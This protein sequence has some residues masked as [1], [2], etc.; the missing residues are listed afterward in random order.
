MPDR[1]LPLAP[2]HRALFEASPGAQLVLAADPPR[3]TIVAVTD[4]YLRAT[5]TERDAILGRGLFE[6]FPDNPDAPGADSVRNLRA[7]IE[8]VIATGTAE[9]MA[10]Q[11]YDIRTGGR[12][13]ERHWRPVNAPVLGPDGRVT[14]IIHDVEDIT[15]VARLRAADAALHSRVHRLEAE[16]SAT[17]SR[18]H[19]TRF[20]LKA[21]EAHTRAI[22]ESS[23]EYAIL[24]MDRSGRIMSWNSGAEFV[25]GWREEDVL[26]QP[27]EFFFTPE[28]RAAGLPMQEL[29]TALI[30]GRAADERWH[31]RADGSRFFAHG[32]TM[33]LRDE[34]GTPAG[35]GFVK[36]MRDR[37][38]EHERDVA[39][40]A[41]EGRL[42]AVLESVS[43][44]FIAVDGEWRFI[45]FNA[46]AER[47]LE[48]RR[49]A[50]IGRLVWDVFPQLQ[51]TGVERRCREVMAGGPAVAFEA[52]PGGP[53]GRTFEMRAAPLTGGGIAVAFT[54][55]TERRA[56]EAALRASEERLRQLADALPLLISFIDRDE[57][58]GFV[59]RTYE[60]WFGTPPEAIVG[61]TIREVLGEEAYA[62]R[63]RQIAAALRGETMRFEAFTPRRDGS[64][65]DTDIHYLPRRGPDGAVDGFYVLVADVTEHRRSE[66]ALRDSEAKFQAIANSID[67]MVWSTRPD[68]FHDYFNQRWYE[69]TGVPTGATDGEGWAGM[70]H[71]DD[72]RRAREVWTH[73]LRT[74]EPYRIEYRLRHRSGQYR[75]VLGRAQ[76]VRDEDG[77]IIRWFGTCTDIQDIVEAR[78]VLARSREDLERLVEERTAERDRIWHN[79]NE[80][81]AVF[82]FD[83]LRRAINPAWSRVLGYD[84]ETLL[85]TPFTEVT[86]PDDLPRLKDA[87]Q[88]LA[89]GERIVAFEDRLRHADGSYRH[90]SWTGVPGDDVFY[91]IGRDVT[92][93]RIAEEQLRQAQKMEAVGQL[94]GGVAHDFNNLL[95]IIKSSTDLLR[96]PDLPEER[97]RR[98]VDAIADTVDR[99]S[100]LTGQLLAFARRQALKPEVFDVSER[101]RSVADMLSTVV[102]AR[103]RIETE[104]V[105]ETCFVEADLSQFETALINM[106]VNAR[107]AMAGEGTLRVAVRLVEGAAGLR[108]GAETVAVSLTDTGSGIA[109]ERLA[110]IFEPFFTTKEVGKGTGLGLSQ[111]Y[112]FAKQSGGDVD[113]ESEVGRGSTFTLYLPRVEGPG[114][115]GVAAV[116]EIRAR[117]AEH[118][119]GRRVLVVEDNAEVGTFS[120]Q[121]LQDLGY[122]TVWATN[123]E[124]ALACLA[125]SEPFDVVFSDVVMPGMSGVELGR[126]IRRRHPGLPVV[127]TSGYSEV[128]AEEGRHGFELLQKPYA[129][130][131]L[132]RVLRRVTRG[133]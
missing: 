58:Y 72:R 30:Q 62:A 83:G 66:R 63:R 64:R 44:G 38:A 36:V 73:S 39:L 28:D 124:E 133:G 69:Y 131:E 46:A 93:Q 111:V 84:E 102:G 15:E 118:G 59:N 7:S 33:P 43:D 3:F 71:A 45:L 89:G 117:P 20:A 42:Q 75:W 1:P 119:R 116:E 35:E 60:E 19:E 97:R 16:A 108:G 32:V 86:H 107:D 10:D 115:E 114:L 11:R 74:G 91:A 4:A 87:V 25:M 98:Y 57:R 68:G 82:G 85:N 12:F 14:H 9:R 27:C 6:V 121:I 76:P 13:E 47:L 54:D 104:I 40:R 23:T 100:K 112:G 127:L 34:A 51:G 8:R 67:Q 122:E 2:D 129:A 61:R 55:V 53:Q 128:L 24:S 78:E 110:H 113:V 18:L 37:T 105:C 130:E 48:H 92:D 17:R 125:A 94:T 109:P 49:D 77:R 52:R 88:R 99:A 26:G 103:I 29:R 96:R 120:T 41:S 106:A 95:T 101:V 126:E 50:V 21:M 80:L 31:L 65:R 70:F 56:H 123:A 132:S 90:I 79:S 81:M 5:A 22:V